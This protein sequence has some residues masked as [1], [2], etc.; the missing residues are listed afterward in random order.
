MSRD[1]SSQSGCKA[2]TARD[3]DILVSGVW[4]PVL[5]L[6]ADRFPGMFSV[7]IA[8]TF[9]RC[10]LGVHS[11]LA[12]L[13]HAVDGSP[14]VRRQGEVARRIHSHPATRV[15]HEKWK[16]SLYMQ[17]RTIQYNTV[18]LNDYYVN[19]NSRYDKCSASC[20][21]KK[22]VDELIGYAN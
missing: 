21:C 1:I 5:D 8:N 2:T 14:G 19:I 11:F 10:Y 12:A 6:L 16:L 9:A 15:F 3:V 20:V 18:S 22:C 17:V 13:S 7:G 4:L